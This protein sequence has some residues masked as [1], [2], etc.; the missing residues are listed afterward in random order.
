[1]MTDDP[2][3]PK[4]FKIDFNEDLKNIN[5]KLIETGINASLTFKEKLNNEMFSGNLKGEILKSKFK[6]NFTYYFF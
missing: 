4:K 3:V 1:M 5:F 2:Q 6:I